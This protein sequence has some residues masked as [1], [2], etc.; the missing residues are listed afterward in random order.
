MPNELRECALFKDICG[1]MIAG[2]IEA[3]PCHAQEYGKGA[4]VISK[5]EAQDR[6]GVILSGSCG[7]YTDSPS[8]EPTMIGIADKDYLF[9]FVARFYHKG[10]S[11]TTLFARCQCKIAWFAIPADMTAQAFI[12]KADSRVI[13]NIFAILTAHIEHDFERMYLV[14]SHSVRTRLTRYLLSEWRKHGS[15]AIKHAFS[16]TELASFL[17]VYRTS[18]SHE[19]KKMC[20]SSLI[21]EGRHCFRILDLEGLLQIEQ[22]D[23]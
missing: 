13:S 11:I 18:L 4:C 22:A 1:D 8:G 3:F 9:G 5:D 15:M 7:I 19:T 16:K 2:F 10:R 20:D 17:G 6:I 14:G 12:E 21:S 23:D